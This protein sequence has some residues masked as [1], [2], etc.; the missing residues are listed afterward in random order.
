MKLLN[1]L[2]TLGLTQIFNTLV[3]IAISPD[4]PRPS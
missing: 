2:H 3:E 4:W 1:N